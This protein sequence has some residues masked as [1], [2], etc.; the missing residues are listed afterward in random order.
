MTV[1]GLPDGWK[2]WDHEPDRSLI[3]AFR[4]D[5]F[6]GSRFPPSCL[7]T[8]YVR[9]GRKDLRRAGPQPEAGTEG[10]WTVTLILEPEVSTLLAECD[11]MAAATDAA[12][13]QADAFSA[14]EIDL[15]EVYQ[16]PRHEYLGAIEDL[17]DSR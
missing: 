12:V 16:R 15:E 9:E 13:E 11:S 4:P 10:R 1:D 17:I 7:P 5:V 3:L 6:N 2:I 14:G 8:I